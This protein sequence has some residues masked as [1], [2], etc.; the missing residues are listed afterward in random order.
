MWGVF[1]GLLHGAVVSGLVR[2]RAQG[3]HS[4]TLT[5]VQHPHLNVGR[6]N[7]AAHLAT[8]GV[9]FAH[10][11]S[12]SGTAN[13]GIAGHERQ[14]VHVQREQQR[15]LPHAGARKRGFTARVAGPN[16][17]N[18]ISLCVVFLYFWHFYSLYLLNS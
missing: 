9:D 4:R 12:L 14:H 2:L 6:V 16:D 8:Q 11:D 13:T 3:T 7:I 10:N 15:F 5:G 18:V 17:D 1:N